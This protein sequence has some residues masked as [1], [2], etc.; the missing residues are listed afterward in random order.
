MQSCPD[1]PGEWNV[2]LWPAPVTAGCGDPRFDDILGGYED[3]CARG[4]GVECESW[5]D[6]VDLPW[7]E[8]VQWASY[9]PR[10]DSAR[11]LDCDPI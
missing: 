8:Y 10:C 7:E 9:R 4:P 1:L 11:R 5:G 6:L 2:D 3:V